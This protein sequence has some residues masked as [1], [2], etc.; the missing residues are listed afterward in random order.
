[1]KEDIVAIGDEALDGFEQCQNRL[2]VGGR[3]TI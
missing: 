1:M 2:H 3:L